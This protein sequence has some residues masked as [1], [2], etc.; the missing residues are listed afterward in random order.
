MKPDITGIPVNLVDR[1][2]QRL[3][4]GGARV[5]GLSLYL[6]CHN[7]KIMLFVVFGRK[8]VAFVTKI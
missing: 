8:D 7:V 6:F 2:L 3:Q 1:G 5:C 4:F